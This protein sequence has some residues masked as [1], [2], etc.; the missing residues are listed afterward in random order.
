[1]KKQFLETGKITGTHGIRGMVRIQAWCDD[2]D[3]LKKFKTHYLDKKG[4]KSLT[5]EKIQPNGNVMIAKFRGIDTIENAEKLRNS[6]LYINRDD[7][8]LPDGAYFIQDLMGCAVFDDNSKQV[9][10]TV[11][12]VTQTGANDVWHIKNGDNEYLIPVIDDVVKRVDVESGKIYI[13]PLKGIFDD[14]N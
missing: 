13:T 2:Y 12:D 6:I 7:A 11:S 3:F 5:L 8:N 9:Y 14:E 10:G 4:V 1:M